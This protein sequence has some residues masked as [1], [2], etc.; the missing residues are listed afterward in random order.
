M[1]TTNRPS[2]RGKL[3]I[4][5]MMYMYIQIDNARS[6]YCE[7]RILFP[8]L[9]FPSLH[10]GQAASVSSKPSLGFA[11]GFFSNSATSVFPT[12]VLF[13][14]IGF[15]AMQHTTM[16]DQT[17]S[18]KTNSKKD[19]LDEQLRK[20]TRT[21][22][23]ILILR[24][25][26]GFRSIFSTGG[27]R[28]SFVRNKC[29]KNTRVCF[30]FSLCLTRACL[31]KMII[32]RW[33]GAERRVFL[34][35]ASGKARSPPPPSAD[36]RSRRC[37]K[38]PTCFSAFPVFVPSQSWQNGHFQYKMASQN[39]GVSLPMRLEAPVVSQR[40][41]EVSTQ[42]KRSGGQQLPS[43]LSFNTGVND[44]KKSRNKMIA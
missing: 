17:N 44:T 36:P 32:L 29:Y 9:R 21:R 22:T 38:T 4:I 30:E 7:L 28:R 25:F 16:C 37:R 39:S 43:Q 11:N 1:R 5:P 8:S 2:H 13:P 10:T 35:A 14:A 20:E 6:R 27:S 40:L 26:T 18:N 41:S 15:N 23:V 31:G 42:T 34:P 24:S 33:N 12:C 19:Q 3:K